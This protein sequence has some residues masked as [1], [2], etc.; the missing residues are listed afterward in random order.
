MGKINE[1]TFKVKTCEIFNNNKNLA[2]Y[3]ITSCDRDGGYYSSFTIIDD[4]GKYNIGD[5][6]FLT[7][8]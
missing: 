1:R 5:T 6:I 3:E 7:K 4:I 2:E 8:K